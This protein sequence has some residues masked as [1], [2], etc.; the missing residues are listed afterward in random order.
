MNFN[1]A[2]DD[3]FANSHIQRI[4]SGGDNTDRDK[5]PDVGGGETLILRT[6]SSKPGF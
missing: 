5:D 4:D 2:R 1:P 6:K 3:G